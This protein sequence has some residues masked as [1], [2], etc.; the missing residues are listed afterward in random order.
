MAVLYTDAVA[1]AAAALP[2]PGQRLQVHRPRRRS[3]CWSRPGG[4]ARVGRHLR[5]RPRAIGNSGRS[6]RRGC[7]S[8]LGAAQGRRVEPTRPLQRPMG[9]GLT[10]VQALRVRPPRR[11]GVSVSK[12]ARSRAASS[13][14]SCRGRAWPPRSPPSP[15]ELI[16]APE[17]RP[18]CTLTAEPGDTT[19]GVEAALAAASYRVACA[20]DAPRTP[21]PFRGISRAY[22]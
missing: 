22:A 21:E 12:A 8:C 2:S 7:S 11:R 6:H 18:P 10:L 16:Q 5:A 13:A 1:A 9:M 19:V 17:H 4:G 20:A 3:R 14:F 15:D